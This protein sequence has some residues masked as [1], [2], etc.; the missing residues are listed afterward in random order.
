VLGISPDRS[1][2]GAMTKI[3]INCG[4]RVQIHGAPVKLFATC[5]SLVP[6]DPTCGAQRKK[7]MET[8]YPGKW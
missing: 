6:A 7:E 1:L 4:V 8:K 3:L 2:D 5:L